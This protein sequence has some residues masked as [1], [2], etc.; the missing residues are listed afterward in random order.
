MHKALAATNFIGKIPVWDITSPCEIPTGEASSLTRKLYQKTYL[1]LTTYRLSCQEPG[2]E[3]GR[4]TALPASLSNQ[5]LNTGP[6][7][8]F[9]AIQ[10]V[11][12]IR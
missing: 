5:R 1:G 12:H 2:D 10:R 3:S 9:N 7:Q 6:A 4:A 8:F 11:P